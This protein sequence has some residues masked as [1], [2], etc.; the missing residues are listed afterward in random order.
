M[1]KNAKKMNIKLNKIAKLIL[2]F[3]VTILSSCEKEGISSA[4]ETEVKNN[5]IS[6][7]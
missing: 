6:I 4:K 5:D 7:Y 3:F 2:L 1:Q